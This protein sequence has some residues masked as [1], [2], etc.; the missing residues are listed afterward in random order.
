MPSQS[1]KAG[2]AQQAPNG[3]SCD[4]H[5]ICHVSYDNPAHGL[6]AEAHDIHLPAALARWLP[7]AI[8]ILMP[9]VLM[10]GA[11][12]LLAADQYLAL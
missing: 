1:I 9:V 5:D 6:V 8:V 12:R 2:E 3:L 11:V 4:R 10:L 7:T